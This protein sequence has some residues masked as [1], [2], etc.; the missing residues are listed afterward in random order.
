MLLATLAAAAFAV[1]PAEPA[2]PRAQRVGNLA[3]YVGP[4]DYPSEA[5]RRGQQ[6]TV[7]FNVTVGTTGRVTACTITQSSGFEQ[8]DEGTCR[9]ARA[10]LRLNPGRINGRAV[11]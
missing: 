9:L 7:R 11:E 3:Q 1:Q 6:G 5:L 2:S 4:G 10:R 8:L